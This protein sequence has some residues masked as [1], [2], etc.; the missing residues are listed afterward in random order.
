VERAVE[1]VPLQIAAPQLAVAMRTD[2][3]D[4]VGDAI[5]PRDRHLAALGLDDRAAPFGQVAGG[6]QVDEVR[7][8][9]ALC[10]RS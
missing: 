4:G 10:T 8:H 2:V 5:H 1:E 7:G 6:E 9:E 3:V